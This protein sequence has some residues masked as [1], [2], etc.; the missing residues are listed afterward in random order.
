M[1]YVKAWP[2]DQPEPN[3][4]V[5]TD[6]IASAII[7]NS[8]IVPA[9]ADGGIRVL[10]QLPTD[11][12]IDING[13]FAAPSANGLSFYSVTPCRV[14]DT[15]NRAGTFGGPTMTAGQTRSFPVPLCSL[16]HPV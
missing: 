15:R 6:T 7:G 3:T 9:G 13:Y 10:S 16:R 8:A 4:A 2:D 5:L 14:S 11:L 1:G 12:V